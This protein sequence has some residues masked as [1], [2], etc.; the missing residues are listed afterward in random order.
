MI[1]AIDLTFQIQMYAGVAL[2]DSYSEIDAEV[3]VYVIRD[4]LCCL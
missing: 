4:S 1:K 3:T 2:L